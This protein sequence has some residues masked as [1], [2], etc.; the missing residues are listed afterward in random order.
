MEFPG[1]IYFFI[2]P[3]GWTSNVKELIS[4]FIFSCGKVVLFPNG[5]KKRVLQV[6]YVLVNLKSQSRFSSFN[7]LAQVRA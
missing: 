7:E 3:F 1:F 6:T 5:Q 4:L 2:M